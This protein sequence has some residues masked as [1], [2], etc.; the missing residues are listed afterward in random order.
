MNRSM[1]AVYTPRRHSGNFPKAQQR[2]GI[3]PAR[4]FNELNVA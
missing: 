3:A 4:L 1:L 2:R